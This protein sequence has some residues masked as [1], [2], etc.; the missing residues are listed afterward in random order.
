MWVRLGGAWRKIPARRGAVWRH[1]GQLLKQQLDGAAVHGPPPPLEYFRYEGE[2]QAIRGPRRGHV[3]DRWLPWWELPKDEDGFLV[4][5]CED[6]STAWMAHQLLVNGLTVVPVAERIP[7]AG[8]H[9]LAGVVGAGK[10]LDP[11]LFF[12]G[13]GMAD[14]PIQVVDPSYLR[15]MKDPRRSPMCYRGAQTEGLC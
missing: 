9:A 15:G 13:P 14:T 12:A 5:D 11:D 7:G 2:G 4:G 3:D 1:L 6:L 8:F 10:I